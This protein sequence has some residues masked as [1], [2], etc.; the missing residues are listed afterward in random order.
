[1]S[2]VY[3]IENE[4]LKVSVQS[5]GAELTSIINKENSLEYLWQAGAEWPKHAPVLF[6]IV[7]QLKDNKYRYNGNEY[8]LNRHGFARE[9]EFEVFDQNATS[10]TFVLSSNAKT[11][12]V[13][14]FQFNF[15]VIYE[16]EGSTLHIHHKVEN[17]GEQT[18]FYSV[19]GH[20]AFN[21]PLVNGTSYNDYKLRFDQPVTANR[22]LL[23]NG[24]IST[25]S[26]PFL[27]DQTMMELT[28]DLFMEDALVFKTVKAGS[29]TLKAPGSRNGFTM[30]LNGC[31]YLGIWAAKNA[32]FVCI[33][34]WW[35]IA[36]SVSSNGDIS[37]KEGICALAGEED[38]MH[39]YSIRFF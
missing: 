10:I 38:A 1:M 27:E 16:L 5:A 29:I 23:D 7:G 4:K 25:E 24:L 34:P 28:K 2:S 36:D 18:M 33:E 3:S 19:G 9:S 17:D 31:P 30:D 13:Y 20:P 39:S 14:P 11:E 15:Y 35:G 26:V 21:I 32:D 8:T 6:P 12:V 22:W 37:Q